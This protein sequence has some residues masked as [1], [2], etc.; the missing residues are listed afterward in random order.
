MV[1][2][3]GL[4]SPAPVVLFRIAIEETEAFYLG[5]QRA[6]KVAFPHARLHKMK[7]YV[8]D[9]VVG[10]WELFRDVIGDEREDKVAWA[11]QIAPHL[12]TDWK[13]PKANRSVSFRQFCQ[14][15]LKHVGEPLD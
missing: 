4:C 7:D 12:T 10:T 5:D 14:G 15:L 3:L 1:R 9:S 2:L 11:E 8:Q 6:I 13:G